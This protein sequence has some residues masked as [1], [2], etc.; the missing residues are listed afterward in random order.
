MFRVTG[1][2]WPTRD[3]T[4][5]RDYV[6]VWD[7]ARAHVLAVERI[8]AVFP[9]GPGFKIINLGSGAEELRFER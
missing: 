3:G 9:D 6:H 8:G 7:L 5:I 4:G 2:D 1:T